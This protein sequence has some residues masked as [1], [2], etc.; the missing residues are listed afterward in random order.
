MGIEKVTQQQRFTSPNI[1][2]GDDNPIDTG[3]S[4]YGKITTTD[5]IRSGNDIHASGNLSTDGTVTGNSLVSNNGVTINNGNL[6]LTGGSIVNTDAISANTITFTNGIINNSSTSF[7]SLSDI[8]QNGANDGDTIQ[9]SSSQNKWISVDE[10]SAGKIVAWAYIDCSKKTG[11]YVRPANSRIVTLT[12][13]NHGFN[14]GSTI[15]AFV[16]FEGGELNTSSVD[17]KVWNAI[18]ATA[19]T[20]TFDCGISSTDEKSGNADSVSIHSPVIRGSNNVSN[21]V[22]DLDNVPS[23]GG[24]NIRFTLNFINPLI[25]PNYAVIGNAYYYAGGGIVGAEAEKYGAF[26]QVDN[27]PSQK[28]TTSFKFV[29]VDPTNNTYANE[30]D[31]GHWPFIHLMVV[32]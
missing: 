15:S 10:G 7:I 11:S 17:N 23:A 12:I 20:I 25:N 24:E 31:N 13:T 4:V 21:V 1:V 32:G 2:I 9:W 29:V 3:L 19:N 28:I 30:R 22:L 27:R 6:D 16:Q 18:I 26:V 14:V 5:N 8:K